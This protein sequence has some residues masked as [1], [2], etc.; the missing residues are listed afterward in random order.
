MGF[1]HSTSGGRTDLAIEHCREAATIAARSGL[2]ELSAY[3]ES[4]LAQVYMVAGR[5]REALAA[6]ERALLSFEA[7]G[8]R[9]WA[10]RTL[11]HLTAI[12]NY[13]GEWEASLDYC[14]RGIEHGV[15]LGDL[16]L[17]VNGW[18]RLGTAYIVRGDVERGLQ[19]CDEAL[20]L[21]PIER[22]AAWAR[23]VRGYGKIRAGQ[24]GDGVEELRRGLSWFQTSQMRW[25]CVIGAIWLAE[26]YLRLGERAL[27]RP[28]IDQVLATSRATGYLQYEA[29]GYWLMG[30]C[31]AAE[32]PDAAED[33][34][35]RA[36]RIFEQIGARNDLARAIVTQAALR[37]RA[38]DR[39]KA[40]GLIARAAALFDALGTLGETQRAA[41]LLAVPPDVASK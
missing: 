35:D 7:R 38:G 40:Q 30:E 19:C 39:G 14:R 9:W 23:V 15:A 20:A 10:G 41:A 37:Q 34:L 5:L 26:G 32:A 2:A 3:A 11:W 12:A 33:H 21:G 6:G 25:S 24:A 1:L 29:R 18:T 22:D 4:C 8:N 13:L 31:V 27:A 17:K 28:L 16:R 36:I